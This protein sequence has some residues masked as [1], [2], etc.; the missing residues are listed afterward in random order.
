MI[1]NIQTIFNISTE[2]MLLS[3]YDQL[4][5]TPWISF[6]HM[7]LSYITGIDSMVWSS[8]MTKEKLNDIDKTQQ[9]ANRVHNSGDVL[10]QVPGL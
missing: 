2:H 10:Y 8:A 7:R 9:I 1:S 6:A 3:F 4:L 5:K